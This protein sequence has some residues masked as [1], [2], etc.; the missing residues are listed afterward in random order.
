M[1]RRKFNEVDNPKQDIEY[2][3]VLDEENI[4]PH[5]FKTE[6]DARNFAEYY[7]HEIVFEECF[8]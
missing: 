5:Y 1:A 2:W 6:K 7:G 8:N 4:I 3:V